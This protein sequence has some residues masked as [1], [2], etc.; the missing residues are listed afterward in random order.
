MKKQILFFILMFVLCVTACTP[1]NDNKDNI[2]KEFFFSSERVESLDGKII[3]NAKR[4][5]DLYYVSSFD[6]IAGV[7]VISVYDSSFTFSHELHGDFES[8]D[9]Q[10]FRMSAF[11]VYDGH[12]Y[13]VYIGSLYSTEE[14]MLIK[15]DLESGDELERIKIAP[16]VDIWDGVVLS[17]LHVTSSHFVLESTVGIQILNIDGSTVQEICNSNK[18]EYYIAS[19]GIDQAGYAYYGCIEEN[20]PYLCKVELKTGENKWKFKLADGTF[21]RNISVC[22]NGIIIQNDQNFLL[23]DEDGKESVSLFD[24]RDHNQTISHS[25]DSSFYIY[26]VGIIGNQNELLYLHSDN[27]SESCVVKLKS[28][29]GSAKES[30]ISE[31][32][33]QEQQTRTLRLFLPYVDNDIKDLIY[34]FGKEN[35]VTIESEYYAESFTNFNVQDYLQLVSTR[36]MS[37]KSEW[38]IMSTELIP[39][40]QYSKEGKF[41]DL[42]SLKDGSALK[43]E[44]R[45]YTNIFESSAYG[46]H[47]YYFPMR[48][49]FSRYFANDN[50]SSNISDMNDILQLCL[51]S[52]VKVKSVAASL[53][54]YAFKNMFTQFLRTD[55]NDFYF[56]E[57]KYKEIA[58]T[59]K[60]V[61]NLDCYVGYEPNVAFDLYVGEETDISEGIDLVA[62]KNLHYLSDVD[63]SVSYRMSK[64][65]V[66]MENSPAKDL[67]LEFLIYVSENYKRKYSPSKENM[68]N[69]FNAIT[70]NSIRGTTEEEFNQNRDSFMKKADEI[71]SLANY[72]RY[73]HADLYSIAY[74]ST[75]AY[76]AGEIDLDTATSQIKQAFDILKAEVN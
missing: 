30:A 31:K 6:P 57:D 13:I 27:Q 51:T 64:G 73:N 14:R 58:K 24:V 28:L 5:N 41:A 25:K 68:I 45:F 65:Y 55:Y 37:G 54:S 40:I 21:V 33:D 75:E 50:I 35:N 52:D 53:Y 39:Y 15:Y 36:I 4:Y 71:M 9:Q 10:F 66:I 18:S 69:N 11:D 49:E 63:G 22:E 8:L 74:R 43:D 44:N 60:E 20:T 48:L 56:D 3:T 72:S 34:D 62:Y 12:L 2:E 7:E 59:L 67:A 1:N 61:Y 16:A 47:L 42:Y 32:E 19:S 46:E 17:D 29:E 38:D 23:I 26:I 70:Y 76:I